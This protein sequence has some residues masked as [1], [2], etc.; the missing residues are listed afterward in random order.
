MQ[1]TTGG[2]LI[3]LA[4]TANSSFID[5]I[6]ASDIVGEE[7]GTKA[8]TAWTPQRPF[9]LYAINTNNTDAGLYFAISPAPNFFQTPSTTGLLGY[10]GNP[11]STPSDSSMWILGS[12]LTLSN[13]TSKPVL[14]IGAITMAK[15]SADDW[16]VSLTTGS[17]ISPNPL[18]GNTYTW[19]AGEAKGSVASSYFNN[20]GAPTWATPANIVAKYKQNLNGMITTHFTTANAGNCTN[21][22]NTSQTRIV[23][24]FEINFNFYSIS[25]NPGL[26]GLS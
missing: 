25:Y 13:F 3:T 11:S 4:V 26:G 24:P 1:S 2:Q 14:R 9:Y 8:G 21:G 16:T 5:D 22:G 10:K 19:N 15:S 12:G 23:L 18:E 7:F 6:G 17:G 20:A